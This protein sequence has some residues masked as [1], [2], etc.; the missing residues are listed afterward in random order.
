MPPRSSHYYQG[1]A[2]APIDPA[3]RI[4][5]LVLSRWAASETKPLVLYGRAAP[6]SIDGIAAVF[7]PKPACD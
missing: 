3:T 2:L 1:T 7:A 6:W 4:R 5:V